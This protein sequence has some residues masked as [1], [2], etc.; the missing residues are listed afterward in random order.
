MPMSAAKTVD[1]LCR[2]KGRQNNASKNGLS[3]HR[4]S[5]SSEESIRV[6]RIS[7]TNILTAR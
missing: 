2:Q 5:C 1:K 3:G 6:L 7:K 4:P